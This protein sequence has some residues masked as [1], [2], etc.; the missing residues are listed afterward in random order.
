MSA[1]RTRRAQGSASAAGEPAA[2][3]P[4]AR[5]AA[6][7]ESPQQESARQESAAREGGARESAARRAAAEQAGPERETA[8]RDAAPA[9]PEP[10]A[11][12]AEPQ[13]VGPEGAAPERI[14]PEEVVPE[15]VVPEEV[16][17]EEVVPERTAPEGAGSPEA[18]PQEAA[19]GPEEDEEPPK[20]LGPRANTAVALTVTALGAAGIAGSWAL[21]PG[22]PADPGSGT[23]PLLVSVAIAALGVVL[24]GLA[25]RTAD[26]EVF[27]ASSWKVLAGVATM[28]GFVAVVGVIGFEIPSALLAFVWLRFLGGE[29][30]RL[31]AIASVLI[32]VAF[33]VVFVGL[34]A[35]PIPHLF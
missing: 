14:V 3:E 30:W 4:T 11:G 32:V 27:S 35:V 15:E 19:P 26:T 16:V 18:Q 28:V 1:P 25:R 33:Y 22:T 13:R 31:S 29:S 23:W 5:E 24:L 21:G 20:P 7:R 17:P 12:Q 34:L 6:G 10:G 2:R 9:D 8:A